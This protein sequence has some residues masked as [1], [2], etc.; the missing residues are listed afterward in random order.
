MNTEP[1]SLKRI[2]RRDT[3]FRCRSR[4]CY[5]RIYTSDLTFDEI[6]CN[7]HR[8]DLEIHA[9]AKLGNPGKLRTHLSSSGL[10]KRAPVTKPNNAL[11][12][13]TD[14]ERKPQ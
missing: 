2:V 11:S 4:R 8:T 10:V 5:Y 12:H 9:D 13:A 3:C 7:R 1:R 14:E 6:A